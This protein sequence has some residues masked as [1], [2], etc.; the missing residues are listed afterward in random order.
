MSEREGRGAGPSP[1]TSED[2]IK[3]G[4][5]LTF[6]VWVG[7]PILFILV[8]LVIAVISSIWN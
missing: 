5:G 2:V 4:C 8:S 1:I 3:F 6:L 7:I